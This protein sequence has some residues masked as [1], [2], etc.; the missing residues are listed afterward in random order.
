MT[1]PEAADGGAAADAVMPFLTAVRNDP[2]SV[3]PSDMKDGVTVKSVAVDVPSEVVS[4]P[5]PE[6]VADAQKLIDAKKFSEAVTT[7]N[8]ITICTSAAAASEAASG[9]DSEAY[10]LLG[11]S[12]RKSSPPDYTKSEVFY[13][14]ALVIDPANTGRDSLRLGWVSLVHIRAP[15]LALIGRNMITKCM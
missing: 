9:F 11:Y 5:R 10:N 12:H 8:Q 13:K 15:Q 14:R 7:L 3:V 2:A 1:F 4:C 6:K